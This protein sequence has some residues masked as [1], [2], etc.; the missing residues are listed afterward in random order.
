[1]NPETTNHL[2]EEQTPEPLPDRHGLPP[3]PIPASQARPWLVHRLT[4]EGNE[5][6]LSLEIIGEE[7]LEIRLNG[8]PVA[9]LMRLPGMEKELAVGFCVSEGMIRHYDDIL[10]VHHC[11]GLAGES[12]LDQPPLETESANRVEITV[13]PAGLRAR[14]DWTQLIRSGCG[15]IDVGEIVADLTPVQS[16]FRLPA[17]QLFTLP[18]ALRAAQTLYGVAGG[19]HAAGLFAADGRLVVASEDIGRHNAVDKLLG[20]A[21][22]NAIPLDDKIILTSGRHSHEMVH[23]VA[24]LGVPIFCSI[25]S[26]TALAVEIADR[27][28]VTLIG[29]LRSHQMNV[30]T[31]R[32][33]ISDQ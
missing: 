10:L 11:G 22:L 30:Y 26:P 28:N 19:V 15:R 5:R 3:T 12:R 31:H 33:R 2:P 13:T 21:L 17:S 32:Q 8:Q 24:R 18:K 1:M 23:K 9:I 27:L 6:L 20:Y 16:N 7:P 4:S 29:Y 14:L 25:T